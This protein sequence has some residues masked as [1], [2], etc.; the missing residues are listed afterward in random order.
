MFCGSSNLSSSTWTGVI[1]IGLFG[2]CLSFAII[3]KEFYWHVC[4]RFVHISLA[5]MSFYP[6]FG[7]FQ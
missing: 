4:S 2:K 7:V 6:V 5:C 3:F 1:R